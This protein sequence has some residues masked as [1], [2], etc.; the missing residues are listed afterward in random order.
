LN[1]DLQVQEC[2]TTE[3]ERSTDAGNKKNNCPMNKNKI[4]N[5]KMPQISGI[6]LPLA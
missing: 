5:T 6:L 1:K 4:K 3:A 2:D